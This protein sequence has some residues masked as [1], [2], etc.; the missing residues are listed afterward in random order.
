MMEKPG[1]EDSDTTEMDDLEKAKKATE[2]TP[3]EAATEVG[4]NSTSEVIQTNLKPV[5]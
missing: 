2:S 1:P 5:E 3:E 4:T